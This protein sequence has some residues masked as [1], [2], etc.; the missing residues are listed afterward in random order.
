MRIAIVGSGPVGMTSA[1]LLARQGHRITLIDRDPGPQGDSAWERIGV[2]QF[3]L[4]HGFRTGCRAVLL[5][6]LPDVYQALLDAGAVVDQPDD[7][8]R[9]T[10]IA[11]RRSV[12]ERTMWDAASAEPGVDRLTGHAQRIEVTN[13]RATGVTVD[14]RSHPA[15][16][17]I[18]AGG[19]A[20]RLSLPFRPAAE[21]A[22][23]G[24]AYACRIYQL[25][26]GATAVPSGSGIFMSDHNGYQY[27]IFPSDAGTFTMLIVRAAHDRELAALR[28]DAVFDAAV[29][30]LPVARDWTDPE[31]ARPIDRVRAGAGLVNSY[32]PQPTVE[33]L[34]A[35][36][37]A[38]STTNP[39]GGRGVTLGMETAMALA[40]LVAGRAAQDW[41]RLLDR[42]CRDRLYPWYADH[43]EWDASIHQRLSGAPID[44]EGP[45]GLDVLVAAAR[46]RPY[47]FAELGPYL[48]MTD[49]P[50]SIRRARA[51]VRDML[52]SGWAP[53]PAAM[54]TRS[55][56]VAAIRTAA[57]QAA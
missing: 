27:L 47:L 51:E 12:F 22:E 49:T 50:A 11:V 54:P 36:G 19:R 55:D 34:L 15:D 23:C 48:D 18:D 10:G 25:L 9:R 29:R 20:T 37:D 30:L 1:L 40:D 57:A 33:R 16:L 53:P 42:W 35:V 6:R 2:M 21:T 28:N 44:P 38:A 4:A 52:R 8:D 43:L 3:H 45:L 13:D 5:G 31:R 7:H 46:E 39:T 24:L 26:P 14:G 32:R 56:L 17:V 41:N